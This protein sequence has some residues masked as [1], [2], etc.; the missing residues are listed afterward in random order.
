MAEVVRYVD[1]D[2]SGAG[3]GTSWT[4]AYTSLAAWNSAEATDLVSAGNT[5]HVYCRSSAGTADTTALTV[6]GWTVDADNYVI[7]EAASG[8]E[9]LK[10]GW[11]AARYRLSVGGKA[12]SVQNNYTQFLGLQI[13]NT[14]TAGAAVSIDAG[15]MQDILFDGCRIRGGG[16]ST[17]TAYGI[18]AANWTDVGAIIQNCIFSNFSTD[19]FWGYGVFI[20]VGSVA[21][22]VVADCGRGIASAG[23]TVTVTNCASFS[24][25][26]DFYGSPT[27][28]HCASDDGDGSNA[29]APDGGDWDNEYND[30]GNGDFTLLNSGNCYHGGV[31]GT[32]V[33]TDI[34]GDAWDAST[35]SIGVDEYVAAGGAG[36]PTGALAGPLVGPMGGPIWR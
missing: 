15:S 13:E 27:I 21:H 5:H 12:V 30:S 9:V 17:G 7:I 8:D 1:P 22:T 16:G 35:P 19:S 26:D 10:T 3:D 11:D 32:G 2:A 36:A 20:Y 14:T 31:T 6:S 33:A 28:D 18:Y 4:D 23:G 29:V 25:T 34:D 24:N